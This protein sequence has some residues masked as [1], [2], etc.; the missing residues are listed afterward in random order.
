MVT[1]SDFRIRFPEFDEVLDERVQIFLDDA[2]EDLSLPAWGKYYDRGVY[3]L[4]A[5]RL[6]LANASQ[7][8][9][10]FATSSKSVGS[11]SVGYAVN[12]REDNYN[13]TKYGQ[14]FVNLKLKIR[15]VPCLA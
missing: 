6:T 15:A 3:Y 13:S 11:V 5:H 14:E 4:T 9:S 8:S 7:T 10:T 2:N 12:A 1:L